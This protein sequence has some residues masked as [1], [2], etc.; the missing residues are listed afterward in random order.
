MVGTQ[1]P[2]TPALPQLRDLVQE[3]Q[4][5]WHAAA[6]S[7]VVDGELRTIGLKLELSAV[8]AHP[9]QPPA[10]GCPE[11][12][13]VVEALE[14]VIDAVLPTGHRRS[15]YEVH[16]PTSALSY[17]RPGRPQIVASITI[18]HN[19]AVDEPVDECERRCLADMIAA[20]KRLGVR[21]GS[22]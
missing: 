11:C 19:E 20:L 16:V 9:Q 2:T 21:E 3:H 4:M 5:R 13:P 17:Q 22:P 6:E 8:H 14:R 1:E 12:R 7:A 15:H 10:P 18:L